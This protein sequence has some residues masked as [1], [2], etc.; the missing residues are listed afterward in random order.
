[1]TS[2]DATGSVVKMLIEG[3]REKVLECAI[4]AERTGLVRRR[5]GN[6][7]ARD[8]ST[9]LIAITPS[10]ADRMKLTP[11]DIIVVNPHGAVIEAR[12]GMR[13]SSETW[14]HL[15][16]Y[17]ERP[18]VFAVVHTHSRFA[19]VLAVL[20]RT[21]PP[22]ILESAHL[23][24]SDGFVPVAPFSRQGTRELADSIREPVRR[25]NAI[26]LA[27]HGVLA[28]GK[29]A[30]DALLTA[31]YVEEIAEV[32]CRASVLS[33]GEVPHLSPEDLTLTSF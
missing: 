32:Y 17:E 6:F 27:A 14:M 8:K 4:E 3:L 11:E 33:G 20:K 25:S 5:S 19:L 31:Q 21:L 30:D 16:A 10:G 12:D 18:D 2:R 9:R 13:P 23:G 22:I 28:V 7:S 15:A 26:I 24:S 1:M 29:D